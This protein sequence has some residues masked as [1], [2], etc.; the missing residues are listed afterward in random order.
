LRRP[1]SHCGEAILS[2]CTAAHGGRPCSETAKRAYPRRNSRTTSFAMTS[3]RFSKARW[4]V[5]H[6]RPQAI[7]SCE[8]RQ[9]RNHAET[10]KNF[11]QNWKLNFY[12]RP[13][14]FREGGGGDHHLA[15]YPIEL[16][17]CLRGR[18]RH[19]VSEGKQKEVCL[20]VSC[21]CF[22]CCAPCSVARVSINVC[23]PAA[24]PTTEKQALVSRKFA[25]GT[26][27][28]RDCRLMGV[29]GGIRVAETSDTIVH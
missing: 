20:G 22:G 25:R 28:R 2:S 5:F 15:R 4:L 6:G 9:V 26:R 7:A 3:S 27:P 8:D 11:V 16:G 13:K 14:S 1:V 29:C 24:W 23:G 18:R 19:G 21:C 17:A 12:C 10:S